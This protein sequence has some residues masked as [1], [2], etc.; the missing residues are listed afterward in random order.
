MAPSQVLGLNLTKTY[1]FTARLSRFVADNSWLSSITKSPVRS[2]QWNYWWI[3]LS[4]WLSQ[5]LILAVIM[6]WSITFTII[7]TLIMVLGFGR[8]G[9]IAASLA[10]G[11]QSLM[12]G[13]FTPAGG[14]FA[15]LTSMGMLGTLMPRATLLAVLIA[16]GVS[17]LVWVLQVGKNNQL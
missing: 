15:T 2:E 11:F 6:T 16:T 17:I 4:R 8:G 10:A 9:I 12:Y 7:I 5:P 14:M 13:G 1:L 3:N